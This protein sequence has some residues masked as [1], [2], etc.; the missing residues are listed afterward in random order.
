MEQRLFYVHSRLASKEGNTEGFK[1]TVAMRVGTGCAALV[2]A[3]GGLWSRWPR[4][5]VLVSTSDREGDSE[6]VRIENGVE[7][8]A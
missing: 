1:V 8:S 6:L 4:V 7:T 5:E 2:S 3:E